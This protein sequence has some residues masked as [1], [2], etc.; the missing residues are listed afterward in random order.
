MKLGF[1]LSITGSIDRAVDRAV[2]NG[3]NILQIFSRNPRKWHS[4]KLALNEVNSFKAK[5]RKNG[6]YPVFIHTP[7][8]L[9]LS[10]PKQDVYQKSVIALKD[11]LHRASKLGVPCV[12]THL[13]SHLG[14]VLSLLI[15]EP[16]DGQSMVRFCRSD[17]NGIIPSMMDVS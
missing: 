4:K 15:A 16:V 8:L 13:G 17:D 12:V 9:N 1:H 11:E 5:L 3:C 10:S 7:Y 2:E 6:I 14:H